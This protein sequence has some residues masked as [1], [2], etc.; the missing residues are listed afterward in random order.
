MISS[1]V[2]KGIVTNSIATNLIPK[3]L[4]PE[5]VINGTFDVNANWT[6]GSAWVIAGGVATLTGDG[7]AQIMYQAGVFEIGKTYLVSF[8]V[9]CGPNEIGFQRGDGSIVASGTTGTVS[10]E[11]LA[12]NQ[13]LVFKRDNGI[14][15]GYID[16]ASVREIL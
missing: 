16:N 8:D 12:D 1:I 2:S 3:K 13:G 11:W 7:S 15:N 10:I 4:G 9:E 6:K 14:V 5:Q